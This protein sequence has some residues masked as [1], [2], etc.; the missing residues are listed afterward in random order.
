MTNLKSFNIF[1]ESVNL[2]KYRNSYQKIKLV[3]MDLDKDIQAL[4]HLYKI[5]WNEKKFISFDEFYK[6]Y[7]NDKTN[8]LENFR[9]KIDMCKTCFYKG[10]PARIYRTWA[11]IVT[12]IH[13]GYVAE[14][15][16]GNGTISMSEK[17][18]RSGIDF[19]IKYKNKELNIQVK[20]ISK[21]R[22]VR[23]DKKS[24]KK[25]DIL[26]I[27]YFVPNKKDIDNKFLKDG[28]TFKKTYNDFNNTYI[29]KDYLKLLDNGF[30]VFSE[31]IFKEMKDNY[32]VLVDKGFDTFSQL[33]FKDNN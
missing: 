7:L 19:K 2:S 16:F 25:V 1:L 32:S 23:V 30:V 28:I 20:K 31:G 3:E 9:K 6:E 12:Q 14:Q 18:D 10:L 17:L 8:E 27:Y 13:G 4:Y 33:L 15:I 21:S 26:N 22:E 11:S 29:K 24:R 5:Y